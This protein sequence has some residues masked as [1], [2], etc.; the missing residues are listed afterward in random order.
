MILVS[1]SVGHRMISKSP[2]ITSSAGQV[3]DIIKLKVNRYNKYRNGQLV[4]Q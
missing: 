3:G 4:T 2:T 1:S